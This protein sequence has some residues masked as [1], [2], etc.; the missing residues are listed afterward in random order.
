MIISTLGNI[1]I[2]SKLIKRSLR[3][4]FFVDQLLQPKNEKTNIP[5]DSMSSGDVNTWEFAEWNKR[6][7]KYRVVNQE[8]KTSKTSKYAKMRNHQKKHIQILK[9][10]VE[11]R[12]GFLAAETYSFSLKNTWFQNIDYFF[13]LISD[14]PPPRA[15][16]FMIYVYENNIQSC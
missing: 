14:D 12:N 5:F 10:E 8:K 15:I 9:I 6:S 1:G 7:F 4:F 3:V 2:F 16:Y 13:K 11:T